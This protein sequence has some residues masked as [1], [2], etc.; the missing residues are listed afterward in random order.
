LT[1]GKGIV[2][3]GAGPALTTL[4]TYA[5][6]HGIQMGNWP[7]SPVATNVSG[8]PAKGATTLTVS[9]VSSPSLSVGD[10]IAIDQIN[11]GVEVVND[12]TAFGAGECRS[13][14]GTR[15]LGQIVQITAINGTTLTINPSLHHA[16]AAA[17]TPQVWEVTSMTSLAGLEDLTLTRS[18]FPDGG[19]NNVKLIACARCW[20]KN[21]TS[22]TPD[23]WHVELDRVIWSTVRD[24][25]FIAS[26]NNG[27]GHGYGVVSNLFAT[28][29]LIEN[30]VFEN[31]RH[32]MIVQNGATGNVYGYNYSF[33]CWQGE[34]WLATDMNSHGAHT[35]FNLW[36][37]NIGC[38]VYGDNAHGSSSYNTVFRTHVTRESTPSQGAQTNAR[39]AVD[40][41]KY[42]R[43]WNI[44]GN[45]L[46][47]ASQSW[48]AYDPGATRTPD[49]GQYVFTFGYF[50]DGDGTSDDP[51]SKATALRHGNYDYATSST[52]WD[53]G[54]AD[55]NLPSSLY[56]SNKPSF[57]GG[58][59]W[60]SIGSDLSP[61]AGTIPA[62]ERYEGRPIPGSNPPA[63]PT[64]LRI[65]P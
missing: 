54:I 13:G 23:F 33:D 19:Y 17:Q 7:S 58:L 51:Q 24:S 44:V 36:E 8:S 45:V 5:D 30:N 32:G 10:Y 26:Q 29:N 18:N 42:N 56:L 22:N 43:Y 47:L 3:R 2:L 14:A 15:C 60:P 57:F 63:A 41:E 61:L 48:T 49:T 62:K 11:D 28:D 21:I 38:K 37:G 31:L 6:W 55:H 34:N 9:S 53:P 52:Q 59:V 27:S 20:V 1:I 12:D 65:I 46:G 25:A 50:S 40:I 64:N 35:A 16:Y 39:R 4:K